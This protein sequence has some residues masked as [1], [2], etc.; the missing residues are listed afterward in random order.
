M[1]VG[2]LND[3]ALSLPGPAYPVTWRKAVTPI[4]VTVEVVIDETGRVIHTRAIEGPQELWR[5]AE[6]AARRA[7]FLPF[8]SE[9][10][11]FKAKGRLSYSFPFDPR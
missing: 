6:D 10:R 3:K 5:V 7:G 1:D 8:R 9:R 4:T 2:L 11:P